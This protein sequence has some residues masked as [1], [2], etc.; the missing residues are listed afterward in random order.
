MTWMAIRCESWK[1]VLNNGGGER[2]LLPYRSMLKSVRKQ[3]LDQV[4]H[5]V[6]EQVRNQVW[7]QVKGQVREQVWDQ[8]RDQVGDQVRD[9]VNAE[10]S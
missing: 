2:N 6:R 8:V 1:S 3:V 7:D 4:W 5:Q 9:Q 10:I